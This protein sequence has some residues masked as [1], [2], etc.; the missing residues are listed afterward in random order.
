MARPERAFSTTVRAFNAAVIPIDTW[1]SRPAAEGVGILHLL[2]VGSLVAALDLAIPQESAHLGRD[3]RL[4]TLAA[5]ALDGRQ[6][7]PVRSLQPFDGHRASHGSDAQQPLRLE[8]RQITDRLHR[9]RTVDERQPF[10]R[11][12]Y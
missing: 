4:P 10:L 9:L 3:L 6:E 5:H 12:E 7:R 8:Q 1:S 2:A 11:F